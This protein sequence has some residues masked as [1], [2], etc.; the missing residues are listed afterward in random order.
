MNTDAKEMCVINFKFM[1]TDII[2]IANTVSLCRI[3]IPYI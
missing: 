1:V 3:S 2:L